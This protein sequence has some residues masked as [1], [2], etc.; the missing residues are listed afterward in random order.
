M[1]T[2]FKSIRLENFQS[3]VDTQIE[4]KD[5]LNVFIGPSDSGKSAIF[6][7]IKWALFNEPAGTF[8]IRNGAEEARVSITFDD[9]RMLV[10]GRSTNRNYYELHNADQVLRLESFGVRVPQEVTDFCNIRKMILKN[11]DVYTLSMQD[12][13]E[14]PFLLTGT[15]VQ[16]A[17]AIG[18]LS[19]V[20]VIDHAVAELAR[21]LAV[22]KQATRRNDEEIQKKTE[23]LKEFDTLEEECIALESAIEV[24]KKIDNNE[25]L[26]HKIGEIKQS[27]RENGYRTH[28]ISLLLEGLSFLEEAKER[29]QTVDEKVRTVIAIRALRENSLRLEHEEKKSKEIL[30][31]L[32]DLPALQRQYEKLET[33]YR[34]CNELGRY[35]QTRDKILASRKILKSYASLE[36]QGAQDL[37]N[38]LAEKESRVQA[39]Y[40]LRNQWAENTR[41]RSVGERYRLA[42]SSFAD[43]E[44]TME[45]IRS[46]AKKRNDLLSIR[47]RMKSVALDASQSRTDFDRWNQHQISLIH[48]YERVLQKLGRCPFCMQP[49]DE[50]DAMQILA[51]IKGGEGGLL[52]GTDG[53]EEKY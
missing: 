44:R 32:L 5:G 47:A 7:G 30:D 39:L 36:V 24:A 10:R 16:K 29:T 28:R 15:S 40:D 13:L 23:A 37:M 12:Q 6:R 50:H 43:A 52:K 21:E 11:G 26:I 48:K 45:R 17:T 20:H 53:A 31:A 49:I 18:R 1:T 27:L 42:F 9:G 8:F 38:A 34:E 51:E 35:V 19:G 3:H 2:K 41:R 33:K 14:G 25:A 46:L 22:S 4:L